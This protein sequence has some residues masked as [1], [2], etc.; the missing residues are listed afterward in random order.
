M[1]I[2]ST[3][4]Q[5]VTATRGETRLH[6]AE[7]RCEDVCQMDDRYGYQDL[8]GLSQRSMELISLD[9]GLVTLFSNPLSLLAARTCSSR[10]ELEPTVEDGQSSNIFQ[11]V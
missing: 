11:L 5:Y 1:S 7:L 6:Q 10:L 8:C 3:R 4:I 2:S 9:L